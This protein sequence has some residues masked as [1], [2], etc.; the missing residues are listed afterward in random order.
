MTLNPIHNGDKIKYLWLYTPNPIY[1]GNDKDNV[2]AFPDFLP[3]ELELD[4]YVDYELAFEKQFLDP[5]HEVTKV[6][7]WHTEKVSTLGGA[8]QRQLELDKAS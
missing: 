8:F 7:G 6:I 2:I 4:D 1:Q 5:L 3:R